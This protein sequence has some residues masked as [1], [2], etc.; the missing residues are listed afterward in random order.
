[1]K[2]LKKYANGGKTIESKRDIKMGGSTHSVSKERRG[3]KKTF[4][5][6]TSIS[7]PKHLG[8]TGRTEKFYKTVEREGKE[9]KSKEI[10]ERKYMRKS[11]RYNKKLDR[12]K[13]IT[14]SSAHRGRS[15]TRTGTFEGGGKMKE[16][17]HGGKMKYEN[18]GTIGRAPGGQRNERRKERMRKRLSGGADNPG[19]GGVKGMDTASFKKMREARRRDAIKKRFPGGYKGK[20]MED[21]GVNKPSRFDKKFARKRKKYEKDVKK[22]RTQEMPH[23]R[24]FKFRK[25]GDSIFKKRGK[26]TVETEDERS[27]RMANMKSSG[28][29]PDTLTPAEETPGRRRVPNRQPNRPKRRIETR[30]KA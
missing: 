7:T 10:S 18:G 30:R 27:E 14:S 8:G 21:G 19:R 2:I 5:R 12:S 22:G 26:Y 1:M 29:Y 6:Q 11:K 16:Y 25:K 24:T 3:K 28:K 13:N 20:E 15:S 23:K 4:S 17:G 9:P